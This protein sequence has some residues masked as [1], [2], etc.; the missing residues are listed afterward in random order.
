MD[1]G[2]MHD[3]C[4]RDATDEGRI[5]LEIWAKGYRARKVSGTFLCLCNDQARTETLVGC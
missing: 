2:E 3:D 1:D 4:R 5:S